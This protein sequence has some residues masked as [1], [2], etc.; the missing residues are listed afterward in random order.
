MSIKYC[1]YSINV[2]RW[3]NLFLP[4]TRGDHMPGTRWDQRFFASTRGRIV[5][6]LRRASRTVDE[7]AEALDLTDNAVR[8]HLATLERDGL[9]EQKGLRR[10]VG[11]PAFS[12]VLTPEADAL[13]PKAYGPV[14]RQLLDVL[15]ERLSPETL[16]E[17]MRTV[18]RRIAASRPATAGDVRARLDAA[19]AVLDDL[20]GLAEI[21]E[22]DGGLVVRGYSC[23]LAAA[24]PGHPETCALAEALLTEIV[25]TPVRERCER[26][27]A[28]RC[29]FEVVGNGHTA[30]EAP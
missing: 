22:Q 4:A 6:L 24:V 3:A 2:I 21:E 7:L 20:G 10:G 25:G 12:Y 18:G 8:S 29:C 27:A 16:D 14:L 28:P 1:V 5:Q 19:V 30:R 15:A 9:V 17:L 13:F 23:P 11:K 26:R